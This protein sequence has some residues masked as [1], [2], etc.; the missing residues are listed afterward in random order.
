MA[1]VLI[2]RPAEDAATTARALAARGHTPQVLP[3][4]EIVALGTAPPA[5]SFAALL[6]TSAH[7]VPAL[8]RHPPAAWPA[9]L[10]V[11]ERTAEALRAAGF[12]RVTV[13]CGGAAGLVEPAV[14][15]AAARGL[16]LL[17]AA[18]RV[19]S[20]ALETT[21][22]EQSVPLSV[23]EVYDIRPLD[24]GPEEIARATGGAPPDAVLLLSR[25]QVAAYLRLAERLPRGPGAAPRLLCLSSRIAAALPAELRSLAEISPA[26]S[27]A[28]LFDHVL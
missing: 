5:G 12:D 16:P 26:M 4:E 6:V 7:A 9:I 20:D 27:L 15:L 3:A 8:A 14:R 17:Y 19:R 21:L 25:G 2:L 24:P 1:R 23:W 10:A 22:A 18:G 11:G 13:G 28:T